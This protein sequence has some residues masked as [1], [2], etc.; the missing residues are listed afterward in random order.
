MTFD[1]TLD[2]ET[3]PKQNQKNLND[4]NECDTLAYNINLGSLTWR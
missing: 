4:Y 2:K 3:E 1:T